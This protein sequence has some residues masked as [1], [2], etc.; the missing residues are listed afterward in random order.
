ISIP[1][2]LFTEQ[3]GFVM[4]R[5]PI[6]IWL[7][8]WTRHRHSQGARRRP[9]P[10]SFL[11]MEQLEDRFVPSRT[12][13]W[14]GAVNTNWS[15]PGNWDSGEVPGPLDDVSIDVDP[16]ITVL[17]TGGADSI[18]SLHSQNPINLSGG[19]LAIASLDTPSE[20]DTL[21]LSGALATL[22]VDTNLAVHN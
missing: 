2:K 10:R 17:H 9:P 11:R 18:Q 5:L 6:S 12:V 8:Q 7:Q 4:P 16:S 3:R 1:R 13:N 21:L 20:A 15:N 22:S 19:T 14:T